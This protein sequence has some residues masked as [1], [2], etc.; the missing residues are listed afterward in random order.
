MGQR[1]E[2]EKKEPGQK[3]PKNQ[4]KQKANKHMKLRQGSDIVPGERQRF[5][6]RGWR[7]SL[8][9]NH[10]ER[11]LGTARHEVEIERQDCTANC[12]YVVSQETRFSRTCPPRVPIQWS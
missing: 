9:E 11:R 5:Q 8:G 6:Q 3:I 4:H 1:K 2:Q 10:S 12:A 7:D